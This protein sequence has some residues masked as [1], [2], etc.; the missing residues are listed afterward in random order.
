MGR[1][2]EAYKSKWQMWKRWQ[3]EGPKSGRCSKCGARVSGRNMHRDHKDGNQRN[4]SA[5]NRAIMCRS[6]HMK[7]GR[8]SGEIKN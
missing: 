6:C 3:R 2:R 5:S 1:P 8:A 4:N 7:K